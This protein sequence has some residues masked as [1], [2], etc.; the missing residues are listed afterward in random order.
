MKNPQRILITGANSGIGEA[1]A[2]QYAAEGVF[3]AISGRNEDRL[4]AITKE[5][6]AKGATV[7]ARLID[8]SDEAAMAIWIK[9]M[10]EEGGIDLIIANAGIGIGV[11]AE[12]SLHEV[13]KKTFDINVNG[14]FNTVHPAIDVMKKQGHGQIAI[15]SSIAG[16]LGLPGNPAYSASKN[17]VRAYGE[18]LRGT[19]ANRNIEVNVICPGYVVS[20]MTAPNKHSMPFLMTSEKAAKII[21]NGLAKNKARIAFPFPT[22]GAIRTLQALPYFI[23]DKLLRIGP[24][25]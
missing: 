21:V 17:A 24:K 6:E 13:A 10:A 18:S 22:F 4:N 1:V 7:D 23:A 25:K 9:T 20:R 19:Y 5:L 11:S 12:M 3:L 15:V 8:V 16:F 2:L 14:V